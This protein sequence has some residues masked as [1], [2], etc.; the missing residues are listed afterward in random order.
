MRGVA[1]E[2]DR[3]E[4]SKDRFAEMPCPMCKGCGLRMNTAPGRFAMTYFFATESGRAT[5]WKCAACGGVGSVNY[6]RK[7]GKMV[8]LD[9]PMT[10]PTAD[11]VLKV[12]AAAGLVAGKFGFGG[13]KEADPCVERPSPGTKLAEVKVG[14]RVGGWTVV[15]APWKGATLSG[16]PEWRMQVRCGDCGRSFERSAHSLLNKPTRRCKKCAVVERRKKT[17]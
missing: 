13:E 12:L 14:D 11:E 10:L 1:P 17:K 3:V 15:R 9:Q 2:A 16:R 7:T 4:L 5:R 8:P 6:D